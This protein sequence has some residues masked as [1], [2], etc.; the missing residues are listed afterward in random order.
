MNI[1]LCAA[2]R[3]T[4]HGIQRAY[5]FFMLHT[6]RLDRFVINACHCA[7]L[8]DAP[9]RFQVLTAAPFAIGASSQQG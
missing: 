4:S 7:I 1:R 3:P 2:Y 8:A 5:G 9:L 6:C